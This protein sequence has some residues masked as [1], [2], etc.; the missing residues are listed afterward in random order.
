MIKEGDQVVCVDDLFT[1][2][3]IKLIP[4]RPVKDNI[5]TVRQILYHDVN[6]KVG[7]LLQEIINPPI[8]SGVLKRLLE[9][10]FN[11]IRFAPLEKVLDQISIE[12]LEEA[13]L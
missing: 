6:D 13:V 7:V 5:Y 11:I 3:A 8:Q 9:P 2:H 12:E 10:T 4:T 1:D